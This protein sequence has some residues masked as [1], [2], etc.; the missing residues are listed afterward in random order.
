MYSED[1]VTWTAAPAAEANGWL[2]VTYGNGRFV[3]VTNNGTN[4]VMYS[5]NGESGTGLGL[6]L[7]K[8]FVDLHN[9][10]IE[11]ESSK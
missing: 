8:E 9:G 7:C 4:Q 6:L 10:T 5:E 3:A 1:G 11:V 2:S